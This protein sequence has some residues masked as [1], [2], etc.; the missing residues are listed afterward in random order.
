MAAKLGSTDVSFR[1]GATTPAKVYLGAQ[2]VWAPTP[3]DPD[4]ANVSLLLHM[5]GADESTTFTD[6]SSNALTVTANGGAEISTDES[7]FG[8]ASG[9]FDGSSTLSAPSDAAVS[10]EEDFTAEAW[11]YPFGDPVSTYVWLA[12]DTYGGLSSPIATN[13]TVLTGRSLIED[14]GQTTTSVT[15]DDWNHIAITRTGVTGRIFINGV[16][17]WE[18]TLDADYAAGVIRIGSDGGGSDFPFNGYIDDLRITKGV[19]RYTANF[20]PPTAAFPDA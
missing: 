17:G 9:Y 10:G 20:T 3:T 1:L 8:G 18:G 19:A 16:I 11:V 6:S 7:K 4:F 14:L 12:N 13:G 2:E 5:D 15:F